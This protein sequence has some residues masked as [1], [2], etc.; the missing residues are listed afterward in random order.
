LVAGTTA[1]PADAVN[2]IGSANTDLT[3]FTDARA[4]AASK[5][6]SLEPVS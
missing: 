1:R 5:D 6:L 3:T 2:L 4:Q